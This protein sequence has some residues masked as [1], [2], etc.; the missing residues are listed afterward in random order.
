MIQK[1]TSVMGNFMS[2]FGQAMPASF[3]LFIHPINIYRYFILLSL[4]VLGKENFLKR[5]TK[6]VTVN[7][8]KTIT[9]HF[10]IV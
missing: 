4:K 6:N 9:N 10:N 5:S 7:N 3:F 2:Q 8:L 1:L